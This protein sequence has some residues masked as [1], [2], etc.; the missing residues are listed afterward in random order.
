MILFYGLIGRVI[1]ILSCVSTLVS[2]GSVAS[3]VD[4]NSD[5]IEYIVQEAI[6]YED[7]GDL[8]TS[9]HELEDFEEEQ[10][11]LEE[12]KEAEEEAAREAE[13]A[14][15]LEEAE[16][17]AAEEAA[18]KEAEEAKKR[19]EAEKKAAEEAAAKEAEEEA[20]AAEQKAAEKKNAE[21]AVPAAPAGKI[22]IGRVYMEDCGMDTGYWVVTYSDGSVE[23][24]DE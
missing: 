17:K 16:K 7:L 5:D 23:Y 4:K 15:K 24:I 6:E 18:A 11:A 22:E 9:L 13:E 8:V 19:E 3:I 2:F 12:A 10:E 21:A 14:K 20:K 1:A